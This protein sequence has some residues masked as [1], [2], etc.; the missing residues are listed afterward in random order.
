MVS[1]SEAVEEYQMYTAARQLSR[2]TV[3]EYRNTYAK[4][5]LWLGIEA[6][7]ELKARAV[8]KWIAGHSQVRRL[9]NAT[10][11]PEL[12]EV[13]VSHGLIEDPAMDKI[14]HGQAAGFLASFNGEYSRKTLFNYHV[15]LS[16]LWSWAVK[17]GLVGEN[18][19]RQV[20]RPKPGKVVIQPYTKDEV[21]RL[22]EA[23]KINKEYHRPGQK[24][25]ANSRHTAL[26]DRAVLL[27][28]LDTG[29]RAGEL[30]GLNVADLNLKEQRLLVRQGKG[31]KQRFVYIAAR[32]GL[33]LKRYL[34][35]RED[36]E[37]G[38]PPLF[39]TGNITR[40]SKGALLQFIVRAGERAGVEGANVHRF[41]HT[42]AIESLRNG[43]SAYVLQQLL[44]HSSM[45][46]VRRYLV[47]AEADLAAGHH[48]ASPVDH[49]RL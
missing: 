34:K 26:R 1:F 45:D 28:L 22:L 23:C 21:R 44:G 3:L 10:S 6:T 5:G 29:L 48:F 49:W 42:F 9:E 36:L 27:T 30:C 14:S 38:R 24:P 31:D 20:D 47:F 19:M 33:V 11:L 8:A 13:A 39:I 7:P 41:R 2:N 46:M 18:I 12:W 40:L 35:S 25:A 4:F 37:V 15:G 17:E 32:T 43:M 16:A